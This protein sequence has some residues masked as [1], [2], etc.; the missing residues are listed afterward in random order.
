MHNKM[1]I[2]LILFLLYQTAE[3]KKLHVVPLVINMAIMKKYI[4]GGLYIFLIV[5]DERDTKEKL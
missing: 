1:N 4:P 3:V 5:A 2:K